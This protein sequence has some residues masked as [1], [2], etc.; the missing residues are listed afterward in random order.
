MRIIFLLSAGLGYL[1][2]ILWLPKG[3]SAPRE[4]LGVL[5]QGRDGSPAVWGTAAPEWTPANLPG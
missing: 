4:Q 1:D 3:R 2:V 5:S